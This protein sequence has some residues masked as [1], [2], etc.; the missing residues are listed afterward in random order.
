MKKTIAIILLFFCFTSLKS[1]L[2]CGFNY[3]QNYLYNFDKTAKTR[4]EKLM[5]DAEKNNLNSTEKLNSIVNYTIPVVFHIL[6][7]GGNENIS[8]AQ[9]NDAITILNRDFLKQNADTA[10]IVNQFKN[11]AANCNIEFRLATI[12]PNGNCTNGITRHYDPH[13]LWAVDFSYYQYTWPASKYLNVYVVKTMQAGAA[14]YT[15]LPG[16]VGA[17]AD[18]IVILSQY[19]GSIGTANPYVSRALTHEVG[20]WFNLQHVWGSTNQPNVACGD[21]GVSDT[22]ITKGHN[23]C[24]LNSAICTNG[25]VENVQN[26]MEYAYC[27][28]MYT[29]DQKTRMHNALNSSI[30]GRNNVWTTANLIATGV[31]NP[32][33]TCAPKAEFIT[34]NSI[35]CLGNSITLNDYSYNAPIN[36]WEWTSPNALTTSTLQNG[37][38][39]FTNSGIATI[40]LKVSN[41]FGSDSIIK[42]SVIVLAA[43]GSGSTNVTKDFETGV[44]PDNNWIATTPQYGSSFSTYS[45]SASTGSNCIWVNNFFDNPSEIIRFY[46]PSYNLQNS[47]SSQLNFKYAYSQQSALNNDRLKVYATADCGATWTTL[48]NKSGTALNS[49]GTVQTTAFLNPSATDWQSETISLASILGNQNVYLKFEFISDVNGSGNNI[50]I[51]DINISNT[52]GLNKLTIKDSELKI[53]PNPANEI[54]N[55]EIDGTLSR[56]EANNYQLSIINV[57]GQTLYQSAIN[58]QQSSINIKELPSGLYQLKI[59][60]GTTQQVIKFIKN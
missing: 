60:D 16:S 6:H 3:A 22:P 59:S 37:L 14:G 50:F 58:Y 24:S 53:Y 23:S 33:T 10:N 42:P 45:A 25:I 4:F 32:N 34:T 30:G 35:T 44:F 13:T 46:T 39:T 27:S 43:L 47:I 49:T 20:H 8:D 18:A 7:T 31:V 19:V 55:I 56:V 29:I 41:S 48:Y 21:D 40:K 52:V 5:L 26:Y 57:L 12:D 9:I 11:L 15:Y 54:I 1:Q 17:N 28:N 51:D 36:N 38:L 2:S